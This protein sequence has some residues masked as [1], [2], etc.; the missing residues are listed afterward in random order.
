[1]HS[2]KKFKVERL[3]KAKRLLTSLRNNQR[4]QTLNPQQYTEQA[5]K[6]E[7]LVKILT[8]NQER[9]EG[10]IAIARFIFERSHYIQHFYYVFL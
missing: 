4:L 2:V 7:L 6:F 3:G 1:M 8:T 10:K 9:L 5:E